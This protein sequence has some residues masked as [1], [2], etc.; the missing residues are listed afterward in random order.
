MQHFP[1][2]RKEMESTDRELITDLG[3]NCVLEVN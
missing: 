2:M 3:V 1:M